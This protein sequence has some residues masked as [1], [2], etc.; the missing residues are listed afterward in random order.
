MADPHRHDE[1]GRAS[2]VQMGRFPESGEA[3]NN[4]FPGGIEWQSQSRLGQC[5]DGLPGKL[6]GYWDGDWER[7]IPRV[8]TGIPDRAAKLKALGNAIVP[9]VAYEILRI[10]AP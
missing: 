1:H 6:A 5:D 3:E 10:I 7:G 9:Q 8:A 4:R 2:D